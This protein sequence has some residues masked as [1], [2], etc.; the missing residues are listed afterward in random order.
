MPALR[1][2]LTPGTAAPENAAVTLPSSPPAT[3]AVTPVAA[4]RSPLEAV[5][6]QV[7]TGILVVAVSAL[8]VIN[9]GP[10]LF[11]YRVYTVLSGSM[12]PTIPVGSEVVA[13][14]TPADQIHVGD[15]ITFQR[16]NHSDQLVTHRIVA[17][18][19][20]PVGRS[21][22]VTRGD[23][24]GA[25][26]AWRIPVQGRGLKY[27]FHVPLLGYLLAMLSSPLGRICFILAPALLLTAVVVNDLWKTPKRTPEG[28]PGAG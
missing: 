14:Q 3:G 2:A 24:N 27:A 1:F 23:A 21:Q 15:V 26:D 8:L 12:S 19:N 5:A 17:V 4:R 25:A 9:A 13:L 22:W 7:V 10:L 6:N 20:D 28:R 16:P 18:E 11:P